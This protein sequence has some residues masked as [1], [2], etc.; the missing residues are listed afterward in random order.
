MGRAWLLRSYYEVFRCL[1]SQKTKSPQ[2]EKL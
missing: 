2:A 1:A